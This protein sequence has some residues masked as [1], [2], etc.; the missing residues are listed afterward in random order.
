MWMGLKRSRAS[1][2]R[3]AA[4]SVLQII[5]QHDYLANVPARCAMG[6]RSTVVTSIHQSSKA[7]LVELDIA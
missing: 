3:Q 4:M 7:P 5:D 6:A 1:R 2:S